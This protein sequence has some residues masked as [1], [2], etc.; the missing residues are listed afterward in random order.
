MWRRINLKLS[1]PVSVCTPLHS[2][3][4]LRMLASTLLGR[5]VPLSPIA[6]VRRTV[7]WQIQLA[8]Y[9]IWPAAMLHSALQLEFQLVYWILRKESRQYY[10]WAGMANVGGEN[11]LKSYKHKGQ[12]LEESRRR[13]EEEGVQLRKA[14]RDEQVC[15]YEIYNAYTCWIC[16]VLVFN[17]WYQAAWNPH[18]FACDFCLLQLAKRRNLDVQLPPDFPEEVSYPE[19]RSGRLAL[20]V[21]GGSA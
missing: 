13:R 19:V 2:E 15:C 9:C 1:V 12:D 11:R 6:I 21:Y 7:R 14:K 17:T 16:I 3:S 20:H 5:L 8:C 18:L 4:T 10:T